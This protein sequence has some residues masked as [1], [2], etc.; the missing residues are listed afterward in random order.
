MHTTRE[1]KS[2]Q[3]PTTWR[4]EHVCHKLLHVFPSNLTSTSIGITATDDGNAVPPHQNTV[5]F[6]SAKPMKF[7]RQI[8]VSFTLHQPQC[9]V[10]NVENHVSQPRH[11][12]IIAQY[13]PAKQHRPTMKLNTSSERASRQCRRQRL[14]PWFTAGSSLMRNVLKRPDK[15]K[16][17]M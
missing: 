11:S 10:N 6:R 5:S 7:W 8:L 12:G 9:K 13:H 14:E 15:Y 17:F 2:S 16:K 3:V 4:S 1:N